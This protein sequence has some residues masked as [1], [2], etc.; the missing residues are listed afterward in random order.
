MSDVQVDN[1]L[2][3]NGVI[4]TDKE[5]N[6]ILKK[7]EEPVGFTT[8]DKLFLIHKVETPSRHKINPDVTWV[9]NSRTSL[10]GDWV[11][12][13]RP[14]RP[15]YVVKYSRKNQAQ[16]WIKNHIIQLEMEYT[17]WEM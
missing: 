6:L 7:S 4:L 9:V 8:A 3:I 5:G 15:E 2:K 11:E 13:K 16:E 12:M 1:R 17:L 14:D 10:A